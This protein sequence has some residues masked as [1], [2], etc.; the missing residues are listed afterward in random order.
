MK[1]KIIILLLTILL[2]IKCFAQNVNIAFSIDN[3]YPIFALISIYS[4]LENKNQNTKY[5][6]FIIENNLTQKNKNKIKNFV[7]SKGQEVSF[8]HFDTFS[9]DHGINLYG[10]VNNRITNIAMARIK[11]PEIIPKD[12]H[13]IIY[14]DADII[15]TDDLSPLYNI[16]LNGKAAGLVE[17]V[18]NLFPNDI[19]H[20]YNT[21]VILMD[22]DKWREEKIADEIL[23]YFEQNKDFP[24]IVPDQDLVNLVLKDRITTIPSKWNNQTKPYWNLCPDEEKG[25]HHYFCGDKPWNFPKTDYYTYKLYY[26]YWNR[27]PF[28]NYKYYYYFKFAKLIYLRNITNI[29][30]NIQNTIESIKQICVSQ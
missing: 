16:D 23:S 13:K 10:G 18:E 19:E 2:P 27:S 22:A 15:V 12:I 25:I 26:E 11:I 6:F 3:N 24:Y 21:G 7:K 29:K 8:I 9:I 30:D 1:K 20:Y 28:K 14:L 17:D 4:I 5:N